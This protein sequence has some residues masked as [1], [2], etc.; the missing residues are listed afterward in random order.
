MLV[1]SEPAWLRRQVAT[2]FFYCS[3]TREAAAGRPC[4]PR[5]N[6]TSCDKE[7][8]PLNPEWSDSDPEF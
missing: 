6:G 7:W 5:K 2:N 4:R 3:A 1:C 8:Y